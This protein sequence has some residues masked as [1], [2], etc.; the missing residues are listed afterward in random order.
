MTLNLIFR[1]SKTVRICPSQN[2]ILNKCCPED[3]LWDAEKYLC[4]K[5]PNRF[6]PTFESNSERRKHLRIPFQVY[7]KKVPEI[8]NQSS[9]TSR[10]FKLSS[11]SLL[12]CPDGF[13]LKIYISDQCSRYVL[14]FSKFATYSVQFKPDKSGMAWHFVGCFI[15]FTFAWRWKAIKS[16][17]SDLICFIIDWLIKSKHYLWC[18]ILQ[19]DW[20]QLCPWVL[21]NPESWLLTL[22]VCSS[23][24]MTSSSLLGK[25]TRMNDSISQCLHELP[26]EICRFKITQTGIE[27]ETASGLFHRKSGMNMLRHENY[28]VDGY[29]NNPLCYYINTTTD[30]EVIQRRCIESLNDFLMFCEPSGTLEKSVSSF[31][32]LCNFIGY[33]HTKGKVLL[34]WKKCTLI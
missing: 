23:R 5:A 13:E 32:S 8:R 11:S 9:T 7:S 10:N 20:I 12:I 15:C 22:N 29:F 25:L 6:R 31:N 33:A 21:H 19:R 1:E 16:K 26:Y 28:C 27:Y 3:E 2:L 30:N 34:L 14:Y 24:S 18:K 17:K 4:R